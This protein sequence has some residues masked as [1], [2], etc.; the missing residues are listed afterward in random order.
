MPSLLIFKDVNKKQEFGDGLPPGSY[1]Y[2]DGNRRTL[3]RAYSPS[4]S[5]SVSLN[6]KFQGKSFYF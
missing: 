6:T 5:Q 1:V 4:G 2:R 3:A